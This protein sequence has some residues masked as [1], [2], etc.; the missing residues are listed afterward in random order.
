MA[1]RKKKSRKKSGKKKRGKALRRKS[2]RKTAK[3]KTAKRKTAKRKTA[4]RK[5]RSAKSRKADRARVAA[6]QPYEVDYLARKHGK[7]PDEVKAAIARVGNM[8]DK[9]EAELMKP[10]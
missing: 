6:S 10:F 2:A 3:R 4:K 1:G 8:R 9:I 7:T 5:T